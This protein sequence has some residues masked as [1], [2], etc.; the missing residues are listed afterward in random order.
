MFARKDFLVVAG[1][2]KARTR[3][4]PRHVTSLSLFEPPAGVNFRR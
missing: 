4:T 2:T 1:E 3:F